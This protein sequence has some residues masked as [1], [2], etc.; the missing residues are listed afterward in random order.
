[1]ETRER[2]ATDAAGDLDP[3]KGALPAVCAPLEPM[4]LVREGWIGGSVPNFLMTLVLIAIVAGVVADG[5]GW[6]ETPAESAWAMGGIAVLCALAGVR[7]GWMLR[8]RHEY[9]LDPDGISQWRS[10]APPAVSEW[11]SI[12]WRDIADRDAKVEGSLGS[13][14][15][16]SRDRRYIVLEEDPA[17]PRTIE[18]IR[19]FMAEAERHPRAAILPP[20]SHGSNLDAGTSFLGMSALDLVG[21]VAPFLAASA[22]AARVWGVPAEPTGAGLAL[23]VVLAGGLRLWTEL[24][25]SDIAY[26]DR[27]ARTW[28]RRMRNRLRRLL[29]IRHV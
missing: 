28:W 25:S 16:V 23:L 14:G 3:A 4:M 19:R 22:I 12:A 9:L 18:F 17:S 11:T 15:V 24:D 29:G 20:A 6:M 26:A 13:L 1:M 5:L 10:D 2:T 21:G 8:W 27:G 7:L